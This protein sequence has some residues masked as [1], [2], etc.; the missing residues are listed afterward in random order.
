MPA[1]ALPRADEGTLAG[2]LPSECLVVIPVGQPPFGDSPGL[3]AGLPSPA[4]A[5][6]SSLLPPRGFFH[7]CVGAS[8]LQAGCSHNQVF[9]VCVCGG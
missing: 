5:G 8:E 2:V 3:A 9:C 6:T 4:A 7:P 1:G